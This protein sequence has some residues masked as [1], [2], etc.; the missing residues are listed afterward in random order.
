MSSSLE[1]LLYASNVA[2]T[3]VMIEY[4]LEFMPLGIF[5]AWQVDHPNPI[6]SSLAKKTSQQSA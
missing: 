2:T 6:S 3:S 4:W 5:T 1:W